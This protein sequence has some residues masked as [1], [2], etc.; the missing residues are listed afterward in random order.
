[1]NIL[2]IK[3]KKLDVSRL[4]IQQLSSQEERYVTGCLAE[5]FIGRLGYDITPKNLKKMCKLIRK[6]ERRRPWW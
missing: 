3:R 6:F 2:R 5:D 1:M 4:F